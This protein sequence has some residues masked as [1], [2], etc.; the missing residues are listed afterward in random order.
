MS[1]R[2]KCLKLHIRPWLQKNA[3]D[4]WSLPG[5][6]WLVVT[7]CIQLLFGVT[8]PVNWPP[9]WMSFV[10]YRDEITNDILFLGLWGGE[11]AHKQRPTKSWTMPRHPRR[12]EAAANHSVSPEASE[13]FG[14]S[15]REVRWAWLRT[16]C[17]ATTWSARHIGKNDPPKKTWMVA[18]RQNLKSKRHKLGLEVDLTFGFVWK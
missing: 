8:N 2:F 6:N 9:L 1:A 13:V 7:S 14:V 17:D 3:D 10:G 16:A 11:N 12:M 18:L 5:A 4:Q 15:G